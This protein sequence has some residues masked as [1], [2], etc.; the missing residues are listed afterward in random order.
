MIKIDW[1]PITLLEGLELADVSHADSIKVL[2]CLDKLAAFVEETWLHDNDA[3]MVDHH[4]QQGWRLAAE[5][6]GVQSE[7][8]LA[9]PHSTVR[10]L[11]E[12]DEE[13]E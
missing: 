4:R 12:E 7:Y 6:G 3:F 8:G 9:F 10:A 11:T 13:T 5:G 2:E 1:K